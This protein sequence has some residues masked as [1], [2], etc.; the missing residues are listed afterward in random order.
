MARNPVML[1]ALA[2]VHWNERRLPEQRADLYESI[3]RWLSRAREQRPGREK[4]DRTV[5]LL[6]ELALAMQSHPEGMHTQV[7]RG[8]A[9]DALAPEWATG[10]V[11]QRARNRAEAFLNAEELD[12]GIIVGR[13]N[14]VQFW[15]RTFQE[16]LAARA[17]AARPE[18]R[19]ADAAVGPARAAV[20]AGMAGGRA[21]AGRRAAPARPRE[22]GQPGP[23]RS[24]TDCRRMRSWPPKPGVPGC[25]APSSA[26]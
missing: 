10:P 7:G 16:F 8:W 19:P 23:H 22:G 11:D 18:A 17:I 13:G 14:Q 20:P 15:H 12:S 5:E 6:R 4:A 26:I 21:A 9:I 24:W 1:T 3:I 2:V 25:W